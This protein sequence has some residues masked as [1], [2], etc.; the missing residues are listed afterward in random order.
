VLY[1]NVVILVGREELSH[2]LPPIA[3]GSAWTW[4]VC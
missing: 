1:Q 4:L 2:L 3:N